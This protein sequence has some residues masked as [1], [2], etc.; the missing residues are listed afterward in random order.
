MFTMPTD[1]HRS[2]PEMVHCF[3]KSDVLPRWEGISP[4]IG[5]NVENAQENADSGFREGHRTSQAARILGRPSILNMS[6]TSYD[7]MCHLTRLLYIRPHL[8]L[9]N[10]R[11]ARL[12][13][14]FE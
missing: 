7:I 4:T 9:R 5:Q 11:G 1:G 14:T 8:F 10:P 6:T 3:N 2:L 12:R 13:T